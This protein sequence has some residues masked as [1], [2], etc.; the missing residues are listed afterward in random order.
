MGQEFR[1]GLAGW[2][3]LRIFHEAAVL[4]RLIGAGGFTSEVGHSYG[5]G[6]CQR[7]S[8]P[9]HGQLERPHDMM[10]AGPPASDQAN[11]MEDAGP[12]MT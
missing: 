12:F 7:V 2:L 4:W 1:N 10:A 3:W 6:C 9:H 8:V 5:A 11:K